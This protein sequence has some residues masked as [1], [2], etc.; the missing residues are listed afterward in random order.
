MDEVEKSE[1]GQKGKKLAEDL[2]AGVGRTADTITKQTEQLSQSNMFQSV[3]YVST[4]RL[5]SLALLPEKQ[6]RVPFL[7]Y[8]LEIRI[9]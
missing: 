2:S 4:C 9:S 1:F 8:D 5:I 3:A 7:A 6:L